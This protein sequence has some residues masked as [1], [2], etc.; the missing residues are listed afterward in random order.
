M[1]AEWLVGLAQGLVRIQERCHG[2]RHR[3]VLMLLLLLLLENLQEARVDGDCRHLCLMLDSHFRL[4]QFSRRLAHG[5]APSTTCRLQSGGLFSGKVERPTGDR[6]GLGQVRPVGW[7]AL[8]SNGSR[9]VGQSRFGREMGGGGRAN[10]SKRLGTVGSSSTTSSCA[11]WSA[12]RGRSAGKK[13]QFAD[14]KKAKQH[15]ARR[16]KALIMRINHRHYATG[17]PPLSHRPFDTRPSEFLSLR[18]AVSHRRG[19]QK[20]TESDQKVAAP[21]GRP[22]IARL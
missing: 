3:L 4:K 20:A 16:S 18:P 11:I 22:L 19:Q 5:V 12:R 15:N 9:L 17:R 1:V 13:E 14:N 8:Q 2:A 6:D 21:G 7:R 10:S